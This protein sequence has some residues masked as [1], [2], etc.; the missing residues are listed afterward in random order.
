MKV[1]SVDRIY[2]GLNLSG[3]SWRWIDGSS[4]TNI[5]WI[6]GSP[7]GGENCVE[8]LENV[9]SFEFNDMTCFG[10]WTNGELCSVEIT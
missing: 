1:M 8:L 10:V 9:A 4:A 7:S 5:P 6:P 2:V 3:G